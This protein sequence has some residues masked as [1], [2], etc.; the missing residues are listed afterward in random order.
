[1]IARALQR[2]DEPAELVGYWLAAHGRA[3]PMPVKRGVADAT[4]RLYSERAALRYDGLSRQVRM[5]DVIELTH[6]SPRDERQSALFKYLLDLFEKSEGGNE[7]PL[8][9]PGQQHDHVVQPHSEP[10]PQRD[11]ENHEQVGRQLSSARRGRL[12]IP[13]HAG[14]VLDSA[15]N[16]HQARCMHDDAA[17]YEVGHS[18]SLLHTFDNGCA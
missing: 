5:A 17:T 12:R 3:L 6:P 18:L 13:L 14:I 4:R 2:P 11:P 8:T 7:G 16:A 1:M 10:D 9:W 15:C